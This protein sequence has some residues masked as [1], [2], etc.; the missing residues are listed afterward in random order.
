MHIGQKI[1]FLINSSPNFS[2]IGLS[3]HLGKTRQAIYDII[4]NP[5]I[6]TRILKDISAYF[7][8]PLINFFTED[9]SSLLMDKSSIGNIKEME[10]RL[11]ELEMKVFKLQ[12]TH[13]DIL[14]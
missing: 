1:D 11:T 12:H 13:K 6:N 5:D 7:N 8:V 10:K 9:N 14:P 4:K 2:K 3:T